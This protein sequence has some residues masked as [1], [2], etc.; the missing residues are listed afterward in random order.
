MSYKEDVLKLLEENAEYTP[1][2]IADALSIEESKVKSIIDECKE[3]GTLLGSTAV[4]NWDK[5]DKEF[6]SAII[7]INVVTKS[8]DGFEEVAQKLASFPEVTAL[9]LMSGGYDL[10]VFIEGKS[11]KEVAM[12]VYQKLAVIEGVT[13][14]ATHFILNKY[15][16]KN[17]LFKDKEKDEREWL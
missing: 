16:D 15:K 17:I 4:V 8:G 10:A 1:K 11:M 13:G 14:T 5:T 7:E 3:D 12:F 2:N 9:Y 6:C